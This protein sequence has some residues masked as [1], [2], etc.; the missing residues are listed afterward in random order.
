MSLTASIRGR[1]L[2]R[3][4]GLAPELDASI[5]VERRARLRAMMGDGVA[6]VPSSPQLRK[7]R[8]TELPFRQSS[9]LY[10]LTG[11]PE[12]DAVAVLT[13]HDDTHGLT[14]FVR[15]RSPEL[16]A[17]T[18]ERIG[19]ERAGERYGADAVYSIDE[20]PRRLPE[21]VRPAA[22]IHYPIGASE[23]LDRQVADALV[24]SR[25]PRQRTGSG[26]RMLVDLEATIGGLRLI[27]DAQELERIRVAARIAAA[28]HVAAMERA[29]PGAGEWEIQAELEAAFRAMGA[30]GPAYPSIV[31]SGA[32]ATVL[33]YVDNRSR[34]RE[35]DLVLIDAGA[36]W[37]MYNADI[38][39][40]FPAS[41]RFSTE[42][43]ALYDVV[44]AAQE[45]AIAEVAPG[46]SVAAAHEAALRV[47]VRGLLELRLL[48]DAGEEEIIESGAYRRFFMHQTSHWLGL[49]VHDVGLYRDGD[50]PIPLAA[51]MVTTV[52]P[53]VY[54]PADAKDVPEVFRG[55]GIRIEDD[56][57]VTENGCDVI[58]RDVPVD[59]AEIE[60]I[61]AGEG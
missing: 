10:Y 19:V 6:I 57:V 34:L 45:A 15:P 13:P 12:P 4:V 38:T 1:R 26:P 51:G 18:G 49:D 41:G 7:S 47:I 32:N 16:E 22:S 20:F 23:Q 60:A 9:D 17:W 48:T 29:R 46:A 40:T 43:R 8:T 50:G 54:V 56:V 44:L 27:K 35:G 5:F 28:G 42:Q 11:F 30:S 37:G 2:V 52:E 39:R 24:R 21:L 36:E 14:L 61:M 59:P 53:G 58:T 3:P 55:I 33:H 25:I 31:G